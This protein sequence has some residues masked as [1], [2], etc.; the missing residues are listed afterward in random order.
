V[1]GSLAPPAVSQRTHGMARP[2]VMAFNEDPVVEYCDMFSPTICTG[3]SVVP[4]S[5]LV[6]V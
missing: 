4:A 1:E 6:I 5:S 2:L 3:R